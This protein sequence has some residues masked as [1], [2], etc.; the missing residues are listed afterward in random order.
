MVLDFVLD[1]FDGDGFL[2]IVFSNLAQ[3]I[4]YNVKKNWFLAGK[5]IESFLYFFFCLGCKVHTQTMWTAME[6]I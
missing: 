2:G 6:D 3:M 1:I 4:T 5:L